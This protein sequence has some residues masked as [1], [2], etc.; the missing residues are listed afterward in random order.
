ML[1]AGVLSILA[2]SM[3]GCVVEADDFYYYHGGGGITLI[4][5]NFDVVDHADTQSYSSAAYCPQRDEYLVVWQDDRNGDFDVYGV[6]LESYRGEAVSS[7]FQICGA[8]GDQTKPYVVYNYYTDRYLVVWEDYRNGDRDVYGAVL[9]S[10]GTLVTEVAV[11]AL[12]GYDEHE[13]KA[14]ADTG[15]G[16]F[17]VAWDEENASGDT[18]IAA[19]LLDSDGVPSGGVIQVCV[20]PA[21]QQSVSLAFNADRDE[22]LLVWMDFRGY[23]YESDVY[24]QFVSASGALID[25]NFPL[26]DDACDQDFPVVA[27]NDRTGEYLVVWQDDRNGD[28]G[29]WA[30][31]VDD[32]GHLVGVS[33]TIFDDAAEQRNPHMTY[34]AASGEYMVVWEDDYPGYWAI[35]ARVLDSLGEPASD[36]VEVSDYSTSNLRPQVAANDDDGEYM[37]VWHGRPGGD[38]D[39]FGQLLR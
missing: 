5:Y 15:D 39:V 14:A 8:S 3:L 30:R 38:Y 7:V 32:L 34:N 37:T 19:Q 24:G 16:G 26:C 29:V 4:N 12:A 35:Y 28:T 36:A 13:P 33:Y 27:Y 17:L 10:D 22:Y 11:S 25:Y 6:F 31:I 1:R 23:A 20:D 2:I 18:D 9:E 21:D